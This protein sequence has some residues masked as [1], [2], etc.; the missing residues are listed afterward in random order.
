MFE[1][2][3]RVLTLKEISRNTL[4]RLQQQVRSNT[5]E[6]LEANRKLKQEIRER[7]RAELITRTLFRI[8]SAVNTTK[9][10][11]DLYGSIHTILGEIM[12]LRNFM[13]AIYQK[14]NSKILFPYFVDTRDYKLNSYDPFRTDNSLTGEVITTREPVFHG[15]EVLKK[16]AAENRIIGTLPRVW[17]GVPLK[18]KGEV[19]GVMATQ[20]YEDPKQFSAIDLDILNSVSDQVALAIER[21]RNEEALKTSERRYRNIIESIEEGYFE[22]DCEGYP[23]LVN[24]AMCEMLGYSE[25]ELIGMDSDQ[26]VDEEGRKKLKETFSEVLDT[27]L[28][29][30]ARELEICR[31]GGETRYAETVVTAIRNSARELVGFRGI[32]RDVTFRKIEEASRKELEEQLEQSQR[33]ESL[34]T[35]AGGVAHDFNNLLMGIQGRTSLMLADLPDEHQHRTQLTSI[36]EYLKSAADLT[37]RLLGFARGGKY[38]VVPVD[39]NALI[40]KC[41]AMFGRTRKE[42]TIGRSLREDLHPVEADANQMEQVLINLLVNA[43]QAMPD[44]GFIEV[45]TN[46]VKLDLASSRLHELPPGNYVR[47]LISDTGQGMDQRTLAKIFD[48]FFTTK[49]VGCG[50]GLGLA[51]VYGI[52]CNHAGKIS[53]VSEPGYGTTFT[54][55]LPATAKQV[56][57]R[58]EPVEQVL[59]G[60]ETILLVDDEQMIVEVGRQ[61]LETLGYTVLTATSGLDAIA[62][63]NKNKEDIKLVIMD[64]IMPK[65]SGGELFDRLKRINPAVKVLLCSGYSMDGQAREILDKGCNGFIQKPFSVPQL[66]AKLRE[67]IGT[68]VVD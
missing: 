55:L 33:L 51:M 26:P 54:V 37:D 68:E 63:Y 59:Y 11:S 18:I 13:I 43:A 47:M 1:T 7:E 4:R 50:T 30:E 49:P 9:S 44:G 67:A 29:G 12:D 35:L 3:D 15:D 16:R 48:P 66:S 36:Q 64:M 31:K 60:S 32:A 21:K 23:A 20:S 40:D 56:V 28:L 61:I 5:A 46:N 34:G 19:I 39:L 6:L 10:L 42:I 27:R 24:R 2:E 65:M 8:S 62:L 52:I 14:E 25:D 38:E 17:L 57:T 58:T 22:V 53:V 45:G 41:V